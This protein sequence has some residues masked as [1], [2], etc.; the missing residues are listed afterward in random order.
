MKKKSNIILPKL[1]KIS[2]KNKKNKY[3]LNYPASKRRLALNEGIKYEN[4]KKKISLKKA[5]IAKKARLN[6]LRIYRRYS[7]YNH[8]LKITNDMKY[9]D[10]KYKLGNTKNICYNSRKKTKYMRNR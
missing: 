6:V 10:R 1:R 5:A 9:I 2:Y 4:K 3:R 7:N 8:C